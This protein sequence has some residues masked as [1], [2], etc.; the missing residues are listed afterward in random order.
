LDGDFVQAPTGVL[1]LEAAGT[2]AGEFDVLQVTG[3]VA[4]G[5]TVELS[6]IGGYLPQAGDELAFLQVDGALAMSAAWNLIGVEMEYETVA[7]AGGVTFRALTDAVATGRP[8]DFNNDGFVDAA[9]YVVWRKNVRTQEEYK[10]W[11]ANFGQTAGNG[12]IAG[13][14]SAVPEPAA[15]VLSV[16]A[17][18]TCSIA[19][20]RQCNKLKR[21]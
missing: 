6:F 21:Q 15:L 9:D 1:K 14:N 3:D 17:M 11:R 12:A 19:N 8:G 5:G 20:A 18:I 10:A 16:A 2:S 4:L 7:E 13:A